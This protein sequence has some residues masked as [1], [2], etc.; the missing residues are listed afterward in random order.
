MGVDFN[1]SSNRDLLRPKQTYKANSQLR[2]WDLHGLYVEESVDL[3]KFLYVSCTLVGMALAIGKLIW[4]GWEIVFGA[5]SFLIALAMLTLTLL[6][7]R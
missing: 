1:N 2:D 7:Y 5:G 6:G 4:T 3:R